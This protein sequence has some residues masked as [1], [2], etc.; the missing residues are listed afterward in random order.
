MNVFP[1]I[2]REFAKPLKLIEKHMKLGDDFFRPKVNLEFLDK[3]E[4]IQDRDMVQVRLPV[5][6]FKPSEITVKTVDGNAIQVEARQKEEINNGDFVGKYFIRRFV[7][8]FGTEL[9]NAKSSLSEDGVLVITAPR[10]IKDLEERIIPIVADTT[11]E[12]KKISSP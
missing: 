12:L 1:T 7:V 8:P 9:K 4:F 10:N 6:E 3:N 5:P 2:L 11:I